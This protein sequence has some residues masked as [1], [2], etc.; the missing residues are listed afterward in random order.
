MLQGNV[1]C[2]DGQ[3]AADRLQHVA[4]PG[5]PSPQAADW[6]PAQT[7]DHGRAL[8]FGPAE[9]V[10]CA[11]NQEGS[12]VR[13]TTKPGDGKTCCRSGADCERKAG[14]YTFFDTT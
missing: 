13:Q 5:L 11:A 9:S 6:K 2:F 14:A 3:I 4:H 1:K 8:Q 7:R 10:L 12:P